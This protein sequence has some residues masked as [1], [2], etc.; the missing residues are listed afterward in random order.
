MRSLL[1]FLLGII[2]GFVAAHVVNKNP[3]GAELLAEVDARI[4]EFTDRMGDAYRDQ[5][6]RFADTL[7][8]LGDAAEKAVDAAADAAAEAL[9]KAK[10]ATASSSD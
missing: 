8:D 9:A 4:S 1:W 5:Q 3:R 6:G 2:G 10:A 7:D